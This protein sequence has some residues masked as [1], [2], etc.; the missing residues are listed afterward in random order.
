M[1]N[2][3][4]I[5]DTHV[6]IWLNNKNSAQL[7]SACLEAISA[8]DRLGL[9]IISVWEVGMLESKGRLR[10]NTSCQSWVNAALNAPRLSLLPLSPEIALESS[11]LPGE[12]HGDPADRILVATCRALGA[13]LVTRDKQLQGYGKQ[14][15]IDILAA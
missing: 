7:S 2:Q 8:T 14:G 13:S 6:W 5:L 1:Q 15:F 12:I 10:F 3:L 4:L 11:Y 9:S